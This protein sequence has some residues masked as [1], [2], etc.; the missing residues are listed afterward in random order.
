M[1]AAKLVG[2]CGAGCVAPSVAGRIS[3][4]AM[5][6]NAFVGAVSLMVTMVPATVVEL[7]WRCTQYVSPTGARYWSMTLWLGP[8]VRAAAA[9]QSLPTPQTHDPIAVVVSEVVGALAVPEPFE[10]APL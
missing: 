5:F 8:A 1:V 10:V 6:H 7:F 9:F 4:A 2:A 3:I